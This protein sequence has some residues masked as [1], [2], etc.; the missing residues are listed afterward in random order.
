VLVPVLLAFLAVGA[1][2]R[3]A[4]AAT[5]FSITTTPG[6]APAFS[7]TTY[8]YVVRCSGHA[9][10]K[11]TT[12]GSGTVTIGGKSFS[13]PTTVQVGLV[14]NQAVYVNS[15]TH[16]YGI[17]CLPSDFPGYLSGV[18][19]TPQA[20][21]YLVALLPSPGSNAPRSDYVVAFDRL[22]VPVWWYKST[23][24]P[25]NAAFYGPNQIGWW[26]GNESGG[27]GVGTYTIMD[28]AGAKKASVG[29]PSGGTGID[30]HD[31]QI[32]PNGDFLGIQYVNTTLDLSS[33]G[34]STTTPVYDC[35]I[36]ELS[37]SGTIVWSWSTIAHVD[38]AQEN[39]NWRN[40]APDLIHM[41]SVQQYGNEIIFSAR[42]LDA[43]YAIDRTTGNVM[44][45]LGGTTTAKSLTVVGNTYPSVF[46]GQ[47]DARQ[48][49]DG[50]ITVHDNATQEPNNTARALRF[51]I[52][53]AA[54]SATI[55]EGVTDSYFAHPAACC[56]SAARLSGGDWVLDWGLAN[57]ATELT[58]TGAPVVQIN[59]F[60]YFS[61]RV[62]VVP[63]SDSALN[64][65]MDA[66]TAPLHL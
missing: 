34:L 21:G 51:Q 54:H 33:W 41:N 62:A 6:L 43:V 20:H 32:L 18:S 42:H 11:I 22:G 58:P 24:D 37:P 9:T 36:V 16:R 64:Q 45:K 52:D 65:G 35:Q 15:G 39:V 38:V 46:S 59:Y 40:L 66:M 12:A 27:V 28:L 23:S 61:Y 57:Y 48:L 47:H 10:T 26:T 53:T 31:F 8:D 30:A 49:L 17:R 50:T 19:G 4:S 25:Y 3:P 13:Q 2:A 60:P 29:N 63:V 56:G 55:L 44:W 14:A 1:S 5:P 7:L